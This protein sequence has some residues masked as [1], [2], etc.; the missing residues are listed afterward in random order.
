MLPGLLDGLRVARA[1]RGRPRTRPEALLADKA[2]C[3]KAHRA[4]LQG[5]GIKVVVPQ[6]ADHSRSV[7]STGVV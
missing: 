4:M 6:R 5:R 2:Y 1:G 3:A 7:E